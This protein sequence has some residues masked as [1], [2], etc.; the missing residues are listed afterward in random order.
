MSLTLSFSLVI[1][2]SVALSRICSHLCLLAHQCHSRS[3]LLALSSVCLF[4][5]LSPSLSLASVTLFS[6]LLAVTRVLAL[7]FFLSLSVSLSLRYPFSLSP[8]FP[9]C[10]SLSLSDSLSV[11]FSFSLAR[12]PSIFLPYLSVSL[13]R[14]WT[15]FTLQDLQRAPFT[16]IAK[17]AQWGKESFRHRVIVFDFASCPVW[18]LTLFFG[19]TLLLQISLRH[20]QT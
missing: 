7:G 16:W 11:F 20:S 6:T 1:L 2:D 9:L 19:V 14:S 5:V 10:L 15:R 4:F 13:S 8:S 17:V 12:F 18:L 3:H